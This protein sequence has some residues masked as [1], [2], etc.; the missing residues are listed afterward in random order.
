MVRSPASIFGKEIDGLWSFPST[1]ETKAFTVLIT[2]V[3]SGSFFG[4]T[5]S[6]GLGAVESSP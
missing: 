6:C 5:P 4:G 1:S 2:G 3:G